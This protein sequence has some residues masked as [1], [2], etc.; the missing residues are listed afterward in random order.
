[1]GFPRHSTVRRRRRRRERQVEFSLWILI[2]FVGEIHFITIIMQLA[3]QN[4]L[5]LWLSTF[6]FEKFAPKRLLRA[7][8]RIWR[9]GDVGRIQFAQSHYFLINCINVKLQLPFR[10]CRN[11]IE[12]QMSR[13]FKLTSAWLSCLPL[14]RIGALAISAGLPHLH[15][16]RL[17]QRSWYSY[18]MAYLCGR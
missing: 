15:G 1:M 17:H 13:R 16:N 10:I 2:G 3:K 8:S 6:G 9:C 7:W 12:W 5:H 14:R 18:R 11:R 4:N